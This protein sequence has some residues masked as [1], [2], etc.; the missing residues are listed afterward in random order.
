MEFYI[1]KIGIQFFSML[2][3]K[4]ILDLWSNAKKFIED[5]NSDETSD[6]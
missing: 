2:K 5:L 4:N 6:A 3:D 1:L